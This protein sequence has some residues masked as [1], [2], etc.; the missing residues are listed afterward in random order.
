MEIVQALAE[1]PVNEW[2]DFNEFSRFMRASDFD[3]EITSDPWT[4]YVSEAHYGSLGYNGF[5]GWN[6]LQDRYLKCIF[7]EYLTTLGMVDIAYV[8]PA[9]APSDFGDLWGTDELYYLSRYDGLLKFRITPLGAYCLASAKEYQSP[10]FEDINALKVLPNLDITRIGEMLYPGDDIVLNN[11]G[12]A[13]PT[14]PP[15]QQ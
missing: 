3:F 12:I 8:H 7:M 11:R 15:S 2:I 10:E 5:H 1:S 4:L 6:I 14:G 9:D 13:R